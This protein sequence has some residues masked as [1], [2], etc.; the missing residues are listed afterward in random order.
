MIMLFRFIDL[1]VTI[2]QGIILF[3]I[4][5]SFCHTLRVKCGKYLLPVAFVVLAYFWTWMIVD[6]TYKMTIQ[7]ILIVTLSLVFYKGSVFNIIASA[8][9]GLMIPAACESFTLIGVG[10]FADTISV[11]VSGII[12]ASL[13]VYMICILVNIIAALLL[14]FLL[15]NF[16]YQLRKNDFIV[17]LLFEFVT[18]LFINNSIVHFLMGEYNETLDLIIMLLSTAFML[19]FL[20]L[21]NNYYL[22]EQELVLEYK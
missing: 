2:T 21:K 1:V 7:I 9:M 17:V 18:F 11:N 4:V 6:G 12:F 16:C 5:N 8:L 14:H 20:Y 10:L 13:P 19:L 22:Q 3:V 15:R